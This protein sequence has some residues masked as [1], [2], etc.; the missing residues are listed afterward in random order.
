M[1]ITS[2]A[3]LLIIFSALSGCGLDPVY[4]AKKNAERAAE[5]AEFDAKVAR[6]DQ[7]T[8]VCVG[9]KDCNAKWDA[10]QYWVSRNSDYKI[11]TSTN[12]VVETYNSHD[13]G[14]AAKVTKEPMGSGKYRIIVEIWCDKMKSLDYGCTQD[15]LD[16]RL[17][18]NQKVSA[19]IP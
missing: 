7:L 4:M 15:P 5:R 14:I 9:E 16:A 12:I 19:A 8:P 11:Q 13:R 17:N 10:A 3:S 18:F 6:I 2:I 1:R